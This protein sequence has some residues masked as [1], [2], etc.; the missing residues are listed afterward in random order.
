MLAMGSDGTLRGMMIAFDKPELI[1]Y[2]KFGT[3]GK[4]NKLS[5]EFGIPVPSNFSHFNNHY[6]IQF[7][8]E[9]SLLSSS[10]NL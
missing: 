4:V 3:V 5:L 7:F 10:L 6:V 2:G 9:N 8:L 1:S